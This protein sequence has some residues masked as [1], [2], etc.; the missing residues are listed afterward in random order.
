MKLPFAFAART[1]DLGSPQIDELRAPAPQ[2]MPIAV[3]W[4]AGGRGAHHGD[5][6]SRGTRLQTDVGWLGGTE[7]VAARCA[8]D[9]ARARLR[10]RG[11]D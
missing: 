6:P 9:L 10:G 2:A 7:R 5:T 1:G 8:D 3:G 4:A 11:L